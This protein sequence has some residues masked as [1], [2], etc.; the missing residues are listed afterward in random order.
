MITAY[1]SFNENTSF[2]LRK[3][4]FDGVTDFLGLTEYFRS[5][6]DLL[7][8]PKNTV[9]IVLAGEKLMYC[10]GRLINMS[11]GDLLFLPA[12][13]YL[14]SKI[15]SGQTRFKSANICLDETFVDPA[16]NPRVG[17]KPRLSA[18][19]NDF[20]LTRA[21]I[22]LKANELREQ[23]SYE[24]ARPVIKELNDRFD[25]AGEDTGDRLVFKSKI[26]RNLLSLGSLPEFA[27]ACNM[28]LATFKR[29]F[30]LIFGASPKKWLVN[31][32]LE[33]ADYYLITQKL[34]VKEVCYLTGFNNVSYFVQ[35]Y[36]QRFGYLPGR[37]KK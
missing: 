31:R 12:G 29:H 26:H 4:N 37:W 36:K 24:E 16:P 9:S 6:Q 1:T 7:Y 21:L 5:K 10:H 13:T 14:F 8:I 28:S 27:E 23:I 25:L 11:P 2:H 3:F 32:R 35:K 20:P 30:T 18:L 34:L 22:D 15:G 33:L 19:N 17:L